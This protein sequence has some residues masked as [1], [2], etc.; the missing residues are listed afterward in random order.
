[1]RLCRVREP[2]LS[3]TAPEPGGPER[4]APRALRGVLMAIGGLCVALAAVGAVLPLVPTTPFLLLAAA[5]F[6]R[7]SPRFYHVLLESRL[8][9]PL[10]RDWRAHRAIPRRAK[11]LAITMIA[12]TLGSSVAF[13]VSDPWARAGLVAFGIA[14]CTWLWRVPD[15]EHARPGS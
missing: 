8:F 14:L 2:G 11:R 15:A 6:A 1:M 10:I 9:G 13:A 7:A 4:L 12:L 5:C 3:G